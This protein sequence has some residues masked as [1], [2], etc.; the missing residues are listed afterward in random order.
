MQILKR[1][2][3]C[4]IFILTNLIITNIAPAETLD[5]AWSVSLANDHSLKAVEKSLEAARFEVSAAKGTRLPKLN[6]YTGYTYLNEEPGAFF[7][8]SEVTT[9]EDEFLTYHAR[10]AVPIYTHFRI[11]HGINAAESN[12]EAVGYEQKALEQD[13]KLQVAE[14]YIAVLLSQKGVEV[15]ESH[16]KS[17]TAIAED[18]QN[19]Y[20]QGMVAI[21]D[22][23]AAQV[24]LADAK[25]KELNVRN[26]LDTAKSAYNRIL[27]RS[28]DAPVKIEAL[29]FS[30][31]TD[32]LEK[33]IKQAIETRPELVALSKQ[34]EALEQ[35]AAAQKAVTGP[36]IQL[37][38]GTEYTQ[39]R[40]QVHEGLWS[41]N[42]S[43]SW[44]IFD[45]N[46]A[47]HKS[48][49]ILKRAGSLREK[50][51]DF[52]SMI[53]LHVRDA[54]LKMQVSKERIKVAE[55][56]LKQAKENLDVSRNRYQEG[57]GTN[58]DVLNAESLRIN[59]RVN[60]EN[61][62]Y[63]YGLAIMR[64]KRATGEI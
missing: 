9:A 6:L 11:S 17:L 59:S 64:L 18:V 41:A 20:D 48:S 50:Q 45:G 54:W 62:Y 30:A 16:V 57:V 3:I 42:L 23:L 38:G 49:A 25:Q 4:L 5:D 39:N 15:A 63:D 1:Y 47:R 35:N 29:E 10:L 32:S 52:E 2:S 7:N 33:L 13:I 56:A 19:L 53:R 61:A 27:V 8:G 46:I 58:T 36:Q 43:V 28:L 14:I 12:L 44:D 24:S 34:T 51:W 60:Y 26:H 55:G 31:P 21:N 37:S 22:L 40:H